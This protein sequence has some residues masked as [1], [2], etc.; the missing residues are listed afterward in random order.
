MGVWGFHNDWRPLQEGARSA[1]YLGMRRI[2]QPRKNHV[3]LCASGDHVGNQLGWPALARGAAGLGMMEVG[4]S[5]W[6]T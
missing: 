5:P 1:E 3:P 2:S 4:F 6:Y